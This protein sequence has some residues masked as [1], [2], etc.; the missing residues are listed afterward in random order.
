[1][2]YINQFWLIDFLI[3]LDFFIIPIHHFVSMLGSL[4][5][6]VCLLFHLFLDILQLFLNDL[7]YCV[8]QIMCL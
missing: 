5:V 8:V 2:C 6:A 4:V 7:G 1:M 3:F